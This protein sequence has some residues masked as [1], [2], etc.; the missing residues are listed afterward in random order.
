MGREIPFQRETTHRVT[1]IDK[2]QRQKTNDA[3]PAVNAMF[4]GNVA[5][6]G[7]RF[8]QNNVAKRAKGS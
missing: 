2:S 7:G 4:N 6:Y 3:D 1:K 8:V 5:I